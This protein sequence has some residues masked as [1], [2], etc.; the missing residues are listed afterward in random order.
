MQI[1]MLN[2][3]FVALGFYNVWTITFYGGIR[4]YLYL[5]KRWDGQVSL[6]S[7][8]KVVVLVG[9]FAGKLSI[10]CKLAWYLLS[11]FETSK[12]IYEFV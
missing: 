8:K 10:V 4:G 5:I 9:L 12:S 6:E 7:S 1:V 3:Q 2:K 11:L